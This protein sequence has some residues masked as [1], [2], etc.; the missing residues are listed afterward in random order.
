MLS[1]HRFNKFELI[2]F[3]NLGLINFVAKDICGPILSE[4]TIHYSTSSLN[5]LYLLC[6]KRSNNALFWL[7]LTTG[8]IGIVVSGVYK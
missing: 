7:F 8:P 1:H 3:Q 2:F 4:I 5:F 6:H